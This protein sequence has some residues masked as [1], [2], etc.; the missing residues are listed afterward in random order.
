M[1]SN[2]NVFIIQSCW[3]ISFVEQNLRVAYHK[4]GGILLMFFDLQGQNF[5]LGWIIRLNDQTKEITETGNCS[6]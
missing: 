4:D 1:C 5:L 3:N 6:I 2:Q